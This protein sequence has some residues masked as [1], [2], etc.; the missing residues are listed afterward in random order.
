MDQ[1]EAL[2]VKSPTNQYIIY[3]K[4]LG[5]GAYGVVL[6]SKQIKQ[7]QFYAI[8]II[9]KTVLAKINGAYNMRQEILFLSKLQHP[10]IIKMYETFEDENY[11]Y[12]V[13]EY[14][15]KG[16]LFLL[17]KEQGAFP[18]EK[19]FKYFNQILQ[20]IQFMH[21]RQIIH[22]DLKLAN[23]LLTQDDNIK[24]C[25]FNWATELIDGQADPVLCGTVDQM[26]PEVSSF[27]FHDTKLDI[28]SL[29]VLLYE[30]LHNSLPI[31]S[32]VTELSFGRHVSE[33]AID[34][35]KDLMNLE[36]SQRPAVSE[37]YSYKWMKN[38]LAK[39]KIQSTIQSSRV[40][41]RHSKQNSLDLK[42]IS[43]CIRTEN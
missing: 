39:L 8:K 27:S 16:N 32:F 14:C 42:D 22:R 13:L 17:L 3:N 15:S 40:T 36:K 12:I 30:M 43:K 23:I 10:N 37:I 35:I 41:P 20:A 11:F 18:E 26:P 38:N 25:D 34:L 19:A 33:E 9:S 2:L 28:W 4:I 1:L 5:R 7:Q 29:G 24:I 21:K 31:I 6:L